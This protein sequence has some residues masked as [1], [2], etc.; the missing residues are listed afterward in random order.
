MKS[1]LKAG[2]QEIR[3]I[4]AAKIRKVKEVKYKKD[5]QTGA[6]IVEKVNEFYIYQEKAG[7]ECKA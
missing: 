2:I 3:T 5:P 7:T 6:K 4:D 1:N